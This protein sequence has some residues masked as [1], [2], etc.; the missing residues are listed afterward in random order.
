LKNILIIFIA[1]IYTMRNIL[2]VFTILVLAV[3]SAHSQWVWTVYD[4]SNSALP[5]MAVSRVCEGQNG[6]IWA[7]TY[8][9]LV[10]IDGTNWTVYDSSST[11]HALNNIFVM[12]YDKFNNYLWLATPYNLFRF[13]GNTWNHWYYGSLVGNA[14]DMAIQSDGTVWQ[15][16]YNWA[17]P[18]GISSFDGVSFTYYD[19][20]NSPLPENEVYTIEVSPNDDVWVTTVSKG[21]VQISGGVNWTAYDTIN[22]G[23]PSNYVRGVTA[24]LT[25]LIWVYGF[26][27]QS[28]Y[29]YSFDGNSW[30]SID[31]TACNVPSGGPSEMA[32][33]QYNQK[34]IGSFSYGLK[35]IGDT[36]CLF[37]TT[38]NS[39]LISHAILDVLVAS[40][41]SVWLGT[42]FGGLIRIDIPVG[43]DE[44]ETDN[45]FLVYP[46]PTSGYVTLEYIL[47]G[48]DKVMLD[49]YD[50]L[51]KPV[52]TITFNPEDKQLSFS[53]A[54]FPP[55]IYTIKVMGDG[56]FI[57][58][59]KLCVYSR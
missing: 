27:D 44:F 48:I 13:D 11:G 54:E 28:G 22:S 1:K 32:I 17:V 25:G 15:A 30:N 2:T 14:I 7:A 10:K 20:F 50:K 49:V 39:P 18:G 38:S 58:A 41:G 29:L 52:K 5:H 34:W 40:S 57:D 53:M 19:T 26:D 31:T 23:I 47:N 46:N 33:D 9:G 43:L 56:K 6:V 42:Y 55:G 45:R 3:T 21:L 24:D 35:I 8:K 51:G 59:K 37:Y 36:T 12:E 16:H 4:T